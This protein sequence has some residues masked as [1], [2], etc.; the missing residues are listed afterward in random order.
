MCSELA[1][2]VP[3]ALAALAAVLAA[4]TG[5]LGLLARLLLAAA[6]L[7]ALLA[8]L[9]R[10]LLLLARPLGRVLLVRVVHGSAPDFHLV[11]TG[12]RAASDDGSGG[13]VL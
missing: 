5:P 9:A 1:L 10:L 12:K 8:A 2:R 4:L 6:L 13:R 3:P 7:P 11:R